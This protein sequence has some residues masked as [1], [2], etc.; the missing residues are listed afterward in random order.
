MPRIARQIVPGVAHHIV[1]R[2]NRQ[3][4]IFFSDADR[5]FYLRHLST[6]CEERRVRCLAWCLMTNHIHLILVPQTEDDLRSV[7]ASVHTRYAQRINRRQGA[8]GHLFQGRFASY[9]MT[10]AHLMAA[11]RYVENNPVVAGLVPDAVQWRW[12]SARAHVRG[13]SDGLTDVNALGQHVRDWAHMLRQGLEAAD[14]ESWIEIALRTGA[15]GKPGAV[16]RRGRPR[17]M[18]EKK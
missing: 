15:I 16:P 14:G 10:D 8:S 5:I 17:K 6:A 2:G 18:N 9:P 11:V 7:L 1:Q 12:S 13:Q 3:Q 4:D